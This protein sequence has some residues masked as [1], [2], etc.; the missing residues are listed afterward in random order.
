MTTTAER[1]TIRASDAVRELTALYGPSP[2][3]ARQFHNRILDGRVRATRG[4]DGKFTIDRSDLPA[5]AETLGL[6]VA[7]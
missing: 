3:T 6:T 5:I 7:A 1:Q 2:V 4:L